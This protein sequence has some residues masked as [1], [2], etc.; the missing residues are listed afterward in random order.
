[1][2]SATTNR[3]NLRL[4]LAASL[5]SLTGCGS[6]TN[7][8]LEET[9]EQS[10]TI[11]PTANVSIRNRDGVVRVYGSLASDMRVQA[12]KRAY[13]PSRLKQ[14]MVNVSVQPG[15][16][17][18][19]TSFPP[20]PSWGLLD[21]SGTVEYTIVVPQT[22]NISQ[23][24]SGNG[25]VLVEGMRGQRLHAQLERGRMLARSC[26][27]NAVFSLGRGTLTL[28]YEWWEPG[29]FSVQANVANGNALAFLP[30]AAA[31]HLI[32]ETLHGKVANDFVER[33]DRRAEEISKVDTLVHGGSEAVIK[34][35]VTEGNIKVI[36]T[37]P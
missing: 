2:Q 9:F 15:S 8:T 27:S 12:I 21:R 22:A 36:R 18:I 33:N 14:I 28:T 1:V 26:F 29:K 30:N 6:A 4:I 10:Y 13:T 31:F 37:N 7:R 11:E 16:V 32:A 23:L 19:E 35:Q 17:S 24:E 25:E 34:L 5:L 20:K 3:Q